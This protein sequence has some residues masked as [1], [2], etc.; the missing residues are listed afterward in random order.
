MYYIYRITNLVNGKTYIGQH[1]YKKLDDDY[2]GSGILLARAKKKYGIENF[3]KEILVFNISRKEHID[4]LEKTF[5]ASER[6]KGK[7]EYNIANGGQGGNLGEE[8]NKKKSESLRGHL[9]SEQTRR[10][11]SESNKGQVAWN[12]GIPRTE[13]ERKK[14]SEAHKGKTSWNKGKKMSN[15]QKKKI[16]AS[17]KGK[18]R[19]PHSEEWKNKITEINNEKLKA[20]KESGRKDWNTFQKEYKAKYRGE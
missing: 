8:V 2:M 3:K 16:S 20:Y 12:K 18:K 1:K 13:E 7:A 4:V 10:K 9:V 14:M 19:R 15:E 11:I 17:H 5:I 6:E